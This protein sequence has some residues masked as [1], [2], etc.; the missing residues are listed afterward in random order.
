VGA[1]DI[2]YRVVSDFGLMAMLCLNYRANHLSI[3][4]CIKHELDRKGGLLGTTS[5]PIPSCAPCGPIGTSV[6]AKVPKADSL[7]MQIALALHDLVS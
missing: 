3:P 4:S 6:R 7:L 5:P 2:S 1:F